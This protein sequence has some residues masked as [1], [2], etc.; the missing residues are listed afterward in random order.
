MQLTANLHKLREDVMQLG[1]W[2]TVQYLWESVVFKH[3]IRLCPPKELLV[4]HDMSWFTDFTTSSHR[5]LL[6]YTNFFQKR[7]LPIWSQIEV[8]IERI[9]VSFSK[10][11][12]NVR[13]PLFS[14]ILL[15]I[16]QTRT[17]W[18]D[19]RCYFSTTLEELN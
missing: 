13:V 14:F 2:S 6:R 5:Y 16:R 4:K 11:N 17:Y 19:H 8:H 7:S 9:S 18:I 15:Y 10:I 1:P 3:I 12:L